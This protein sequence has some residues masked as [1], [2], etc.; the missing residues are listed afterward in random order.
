[1]RE[2][3]G[4]ENTYLDQNDPIIYNRS[5]FY[6]KSGLNGKLLNAPYVDNSYKWAGGGLLSNVDDLLK[7]GNIMLYSY[8]G[9]ANGKPG[10]IN[11]EIIDQM[12]TPVSPVTDIRPMGQSYDFAL[13]L[14]KKHKNRPKIRELTENSED[15]VCT[16]TLLLHFNNNLIH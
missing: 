11:K 13:N 5:H 15:M 1:M 4:L 7:F 3:L 16:Q 6:V 2:E 8:K 14:V 10:F 9:G 12:W